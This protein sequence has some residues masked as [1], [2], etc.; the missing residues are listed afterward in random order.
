MSD[1][2]RRLMM[3]IAGSG[4]GGGSNE[5][6]E[7]TGNL[8]TIDLADGHSTAIYQSQNGGTLVENSVGYAGWARQLISDLTG[9]TK[10]SGQTVYYDY[11]GLYLPS[12]VFLDEQDAVVSTYNPSG[13][14][15]IS[16]STLYYG[17][18]S[19]VAIPAGATKLYVQCFTGG[20]VLFTDQ[21]LHLVP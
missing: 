2:R 5:P 10:I 9:Y 14:A 19:D 3:S 13:Q 15:Y 6:T 1:F 20:N 12:I 16:A 11:N 4:G 21:E 7:P 8:I 18:F 17:R